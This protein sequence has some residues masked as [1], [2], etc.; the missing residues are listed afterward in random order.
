MCH[1]PLFNFSSK[2]SALRLAFLCIV[3]SYCDDVLAFLSLEIQQVQTQHIHRFND[4]QTLDVSNQAV[5]YLID[6]R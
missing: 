3:L 2:I 6:I 1:P 4:A 5:I